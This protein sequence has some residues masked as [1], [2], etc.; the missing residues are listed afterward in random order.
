VSRVD[1]IAAFMTGLVPAIDDF[2]D[3]TTVSRGWPA[4]SSLARP[5]H[6]WRGHDTV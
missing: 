3:L 6:G 4:Q 5:E 2:G 1:A